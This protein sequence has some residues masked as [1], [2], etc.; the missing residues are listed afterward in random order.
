MASAQP[1]P[2]AGTN[3]ALPAPP[4]PRRQIEEHKVELE[5]HR[6]EEGRLDGAAR[7]A[8]ERVAALRSDVGSSQQQSGLVTALMAAKTK[9][10]VSGVYGRLGE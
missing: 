3:P 10:E 8:R 6:R 5:S 1:H 9:G 2:T 4:M 7:E